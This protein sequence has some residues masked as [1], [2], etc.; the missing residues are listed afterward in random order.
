MGTRYFGASVTRVEDPRLLR[1]SGRFVDDIKLPGL[2]HAALV[3]SPHAHARITAV[4]LEAARALPGV[5]GVFGY[6]DL[7]AWMQPMPSAGLPPPALEARLRPMLRATPQLPLARDRVR[8]VGEPVAIVV[9]RNRAEAEDAAELVNIEYEPL[10]ASIDT[11]AAVAPEAPRL[12]PDWPDNVTVRFTHAI[13]DADA[14]IRAADVVVHERFRVHRYTGVPLECRGLVCDP[15]SLDGRLTIWSA[16]Q[17]P[18]FVQGAL[19]EALGWPAHRIRVVAP[20]VGGGFG[21]KASSYA[22]EMVVPLVAL[23]LGQPVKWIEDR[24]EHFSASIHSREQV[25]DI[26]MAAMRDGRIVAVRD[27]MLVDQGAYN[28]WGIVQPYNTVAHML[29]LFRITNF[30]VEA[31]TVLTN[32]TPHAPYRGAGR[33]E[34]VFVMDRIVDRLARALHLDPAELRRRNFIQPEEMPYDTGQLYRDGQPLIYDTGNFPEA[35]DK[36]LTAIGYDAFRAEQEALRARGIYRGIGIASYV[37]GTGVGPYEGATVAVDA[38]GGV[39][40]VTGACSQGQGHAT[41]FAQLAADALGVP[42]AQVTVLSADTAALPFGVGTFASRSAVVGGNAVSEAAQ[43]VRDKLAQAAGALME[44]APEDIEI[45]EGHVYVRGVPQSAVPLAR[46][47]QSALPTFAGPGP[48]E[49]DFEATVYRPVPTVTY[50]SAVH[51]ALVEVDVETGRVTLLRYVV[52]HDCGRIINPTIV[53]GQIRGGVAQGIG[54]GLYEDLVYDEAGQ[55]L[56]GTLMDYLLPGASEIPEIEIIH[57]EYPSPRNPLG[58]KGVGEGG[59][60]APPAAIANAV[61]D[62]L[63]PFDVCVRETPLSPERVRRLVGLSP[64]ARL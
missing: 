20:D 32:K 37:E 22:E 19:A 24:R 10:P 34:A 8:Y 46:V 39:V 62:A 11:E 12:F 55:L 49:A 45:D 27:R 9:A 61:E 23:R 13:G 64:H 31:Q 29:G 57:L 42:L 36:A 4:Q 56:T 28:S 48:V 58:I 33:P 21:V 15:H 38:S 26:E 52:A 40:V 43:R 53:D 6:E 54:G 25:H 41:T 5:A 14:A 1:G 35:L 2:L 17:F 51:V 3:R 18:H 30:H 59:A 16:T 50:A 60:I 47:V 44:A 63:R 7:A